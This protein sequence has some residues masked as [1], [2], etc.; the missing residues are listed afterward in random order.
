MSLTTKKFEHYLN[1]LVQVHNTE[2]QSL[3]QQLQQ[4]IQELQIIQNQ[5]ILATQLCN[6]WQ[7][8]AVCA[9]DLL[10]LWEDELKSDTKRHEVWSRLHNALHDFEAL[11]HEQ[12]QLNDTQTSLSLPFHLIA[13]KENTPAKDDQKTNSSLLDEK[14]QSQNNAKLQQPIGCNIDN[15]KDG[16]TV[17]DL[18]DSESELWPEDEDTGHHDKPDATT[19]TNWELTRKRKLHDTSSATVVGT[20]TSEAESPLSCTS[21]R[22]RKLLQREYKCVSTV[23]KRAEREQL[24]AT[25]CDCCRQFYEALDLDNPTNLIQT[26]SR[27]R[28]RYATPVTPPEYWQFSFPP[29]VEEMSPTRTPRQPSPPQG[30][31]S[32]SPPPPAQ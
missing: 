22:P 19:L 26:C 32:F 27:H 12:R 25:T 5:C 10:T 30:R 31:L 18:C 16:V 1:D 17:I 21:K 11:H 20:A 3:T 8:W 29:T 7:M 13:Y 4:K 23:R 6:K 28:H 15:S 24:P 2:V 9:Y 14:N